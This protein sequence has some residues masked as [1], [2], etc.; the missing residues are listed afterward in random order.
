MNVKTEPRS[1]LLILGE[2][3][4]LAWVL[5][6]RRMA[7]TTRGAREAQVLR[8][9]DGL[10]IYTTRSCF[11]NP[12]RDRGRVIGEAHVTSPVKKLRKPLEIAGRDFVDACELNI[13]RLA[14]FGEG[15]E[16]GELRQCL[17]AL[18]ADS[19]WGMR[20]RRVLLPLPDQ[21]VQVIRRNLRPRL[22]PLNDALDQYMAAARLRS[23]VSVAT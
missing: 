9:G 6:N 3:Q 14:P 8:K 17:K 7:F 12:T 23:R 21:D 18:P 22:L 1:Y 2:R 20:M 5:Q 10:F 15:V 19:S 13:A 4:G 16:L 11:H